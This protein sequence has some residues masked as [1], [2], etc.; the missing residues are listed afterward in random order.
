VPAHP[1]LLPIDRLN[2]G[3]FGAISSES[4]GFPSQR[5][6]PRGPNPHKTGGMCF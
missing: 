6:E 4:C 5:F 3:Q 1:S 2:Y